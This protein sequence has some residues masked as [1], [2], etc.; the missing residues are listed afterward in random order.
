VVK[1]RALTFGRGAVL[2]AFGD[3][4]GGDRVG[5]G[6]IGDRPRDL[7]DAGVGAPSFFITPPTS[8]RSTTATAWRRRLMQ[9]AGII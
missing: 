1:N 3:V 4:G 8:S 5:V 9:P 2:D 6:E 7:E